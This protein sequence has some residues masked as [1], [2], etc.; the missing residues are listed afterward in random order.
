[1]GGCPSLHD[2]ELVEKLLADFQRY[3]DTQSEERPRV[4]MRSHGVERTAQSLPA[5]SFSGLIMSR[6]IKL[7]LDDNQVETH[8]PG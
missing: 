1:M 4:S 8:L 7:H 2:L 6:S 3:P 5:R